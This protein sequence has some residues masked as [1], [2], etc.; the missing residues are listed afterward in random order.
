MRDRMIFALP[1]YSSNIWLAEPELKKLDT[2]AKALYERP[3]LKLDHACD[4]G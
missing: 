1:E 3:S 2:L 4:F